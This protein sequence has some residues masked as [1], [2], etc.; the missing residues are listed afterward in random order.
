METGGRT[1]RFIGEQ[2]TKEKRQKRE[3]EAFT[4]EPQR[5]ID[6]CIEAGRRERIMR[7]AGKGVDHES[8]WIDQR[9]QQYTLEECQERGRKI[10]RQS[11]GRKAAR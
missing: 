3:K 7:I 2:V 9:S 6:G 11:R 4:G 10:K 5:G 8:L 1:A